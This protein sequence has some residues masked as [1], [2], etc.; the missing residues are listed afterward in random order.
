MDTA[1][2]EVLDWLTPRVVRSKVKQ[3]HPSLVLIG[4]GGRHVAGRW[5]VDGPESSTPIKIGHC[6][7]SYMSFQGEVSIRRSFLH[8]GRV[9]TAR[10]CSSDRTR[11]ATCHLETSIDDG[12][13]GYERNRVGG[14]D[15]VMWL[16]GERFVCHDISDFSCVC[17]ISVFDQH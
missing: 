9:P 17:M 12:W 15:V 4:F 2:A 16:T 7:N 1:V 6:C 3:T 8:M 5:I 10:T 13:F 11:L 14:E